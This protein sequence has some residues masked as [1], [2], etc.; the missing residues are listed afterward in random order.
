VPTTS[1]LD[2]SA[3]NR[4]PHARGAA[5]GATSTEAADTASAIPKSATST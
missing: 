5:D 4:S 3:P 1:P 2:V